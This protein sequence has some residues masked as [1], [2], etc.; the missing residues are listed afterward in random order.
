MGGV[1]GVLSERLGLR[2]VPDVPGVPDP[3]ATSPDPAPAK[4]ADAS[5]VFDGA[6]VQAAE[7]QRPQAP[8][9]FLAFREDQ[10]GRSRIHPPQAAARVTITNCQS[11]SPAMRPAAFKT[12]PETGDLDR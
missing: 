6:A 4:A 11:R 7:E 12:P 8:T 10:R 5:D 9:V 3:I 2:S 1:D